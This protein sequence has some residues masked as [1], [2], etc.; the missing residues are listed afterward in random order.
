MD[1]FYKSTVVDCV[2]ELP[3]SQW[4][5]L[6][7]L[8]K[9]TNC[10]LKLSCL[11]KPKIFFFRDELPP[12]R[13]QTSMQLYARNLHGL[14]I[15]VDNRVN[16]Y[17]G[18]KKE[19]GTVCSRATELHF[20]ELC[21][22]LERIRE[23]RVSEVCSWRLRRTQGRQSVVEEV[24]CHICGVNCRIWIYWLNYLAIEL[25]TGIK[26]HLYSQLQNFTGAMFYFLH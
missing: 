4:L 18:I 10:C 3:K 8:Q 1:K 26:W 9:E 20:S 12:E 17:S 19:F 11:L 6:I 21:D 14:V 22:Q 25:W 23:Q 5:N 24:S 7:Q 16:S 15:M 13:I 2:L